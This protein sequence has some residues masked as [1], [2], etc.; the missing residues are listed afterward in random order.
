MSTAPAAAWTELLKA[1]RSRLPWVT[2]AAFTVA[3]GFGGLIMFILQDVRR[4]RALGL[5]GTKAALTGGTA[6]WPAYFAL[7]AQIIAVGGA[8]LFGVIVIWTFGR[9]FSQ[10]TAK[11]LL[12]LPTPRTTIVGAKFAVTTSWSLVLTVQTY[13]L[14]LVIGA[15]IGLPGWSAA[16]AATGLVKLLLTAA[17]TIAVTTPFALAASLGR[18]YLAGVGALFLAVFLAQVVALLGYGPYF[19]WSVPA[20]VSDIAGPGRQPPGLLGYSLVA[21][22]GVAGVVG[23][24]LWWKHADQDR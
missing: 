9:E 20:L 18:G 3:A 5:L 13:L 8:V 1:R 22:V 17:L 24:A 4:A 12:A 6:D 21:L 10:G 15:A 7:L 19:P 14:G 11:D 23:T 2:A 16:V